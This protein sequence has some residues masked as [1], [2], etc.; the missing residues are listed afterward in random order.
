MALGSRVFGLTP[1]E[2]LAG[3][4]RVAARALGLG[5]DRG[6][7]EKGKRA[8]VAIWNITHPRDLV[9]WMGTAP[10]EQLLVGGQPL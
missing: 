5:D 7:L 6:T 9:Y 1:E 4:T 10:L 3:A 2:C 8:D